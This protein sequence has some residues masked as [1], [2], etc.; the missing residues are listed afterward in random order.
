MD[1][2]SERLAVVAAIDPDAYAAG[3][4]LSDNVDMA[5]FNEVIFIVQLGIGVTTGSFNFRVTEDTIAGTG[6]GAQNITGKAITALTTGDNDN[7]AIVHVRADDLSQ[8]YRYVMGRLQLVTAGADA[9]VVAVAGAP[10]F[11]PASDYDLASVDE[12]VD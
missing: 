2:L 11:H 3:T 1:K 10:R 12:I 4:F 8:G 7:Q 5:D 9:A 6:T